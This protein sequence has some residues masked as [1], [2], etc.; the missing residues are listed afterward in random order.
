MHM[1]SLNTSKY[2]GVL[3]LFYKISKN[4]P[5]IFSRPFVMLS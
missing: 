3:L 5:K 4:Q 2:L 1:R